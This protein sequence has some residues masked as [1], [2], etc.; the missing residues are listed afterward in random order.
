MKG[1]IN[2]IWNSK[3]WLLFLI[4]VI[5]G[6]NFLASSFHYRFD[7]TKE[8]RYT[9]STATKQLLNE[10]TVDKYDEK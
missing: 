3:W 8:K 5:T 9:L 7:L 1:L 4:A 6:I 10:Q 2:T